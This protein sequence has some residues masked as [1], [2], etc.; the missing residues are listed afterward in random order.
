ML[1]MGIA[2]KSGC[3]SIMG[4]I[5]WNY[6]IHETGGMTTVCWFD[7][8]VLPEVLSRVLHC[9]CSSVIQEEDL[10]LERKEYW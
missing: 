10:S 4:I 8:T 9:D 2:E 3:E 6:V 1:H 7:F 5:H